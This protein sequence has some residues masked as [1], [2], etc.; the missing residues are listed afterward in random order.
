MIVFFHLWEQATAN[1]STFLTQVKSAQLSAC[2]RM[3]PKE[4]ERAVIYAKN[5]R[6][7]RLNEGRL[8][9][10]FRC[11]THYSANLHSSTYVLLQVCWRF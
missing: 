6:K 3:S 7:S 4:N 9:S 10:D 1:F 11:K 5:M 2:G 8:Q